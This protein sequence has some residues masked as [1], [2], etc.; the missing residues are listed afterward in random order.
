MLKL[1]KN[2]TVQVMKGKDKGKKGKVLSVF[3]ERKRALIEG[4]NMAKKFKRRTAQDQ[5]GGVIS[6]EAAISVANLM[7]FCKHC[8]R[9]ARVGFAIQDDKTKVR[10][11][12]KCKE[13]V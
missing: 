11:C 13:A 5:Q 4:I 10:I 9:P 2:D 1:K 7:L 12:K 6:I 3:P 8:S